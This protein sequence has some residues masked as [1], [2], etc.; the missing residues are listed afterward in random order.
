MQPTNIH[1]LI[2]ISSIN[3][4]ISYEMTETFALQN[5][6]S[7]YGIRPFPLFPASSRRTFNRLFFDKLPI[8]GIQPHQF[9]M[10]PGA[11]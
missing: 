6:N 1:N 10:R 9:R 7:Q 4:L 2:F 5:K 3:F 11:D 8:T